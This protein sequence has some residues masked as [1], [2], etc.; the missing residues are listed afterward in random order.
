VV[1]FPLF[2]LVFPFQRKKRII[3]LDLIKAHVT[4]NIANQGSS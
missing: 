4:S 2:L 1:L 3:F